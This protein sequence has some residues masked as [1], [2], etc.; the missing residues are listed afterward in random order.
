MCFKCNE[1]G[2]QAKDCTAKNITHC[3][4]CGAIGHKES[5][6][7]RV[8]AAPTAAQLRLMRCIECGR[9]GHIKC[10][11]EKESMTI[12]I[13]SRVLENLNEFVE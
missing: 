5:R 3:N 11:T 1:V 7:L 13:S 9:H 2:H 8:W 4:K 12:K 10:T 6:C